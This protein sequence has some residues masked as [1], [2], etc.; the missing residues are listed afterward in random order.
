R[1]SDDQSRVVC[2]DRK[3]AGHYQLAGQVTCFL[4]HVVHSQP[5]NGEQEHISVFGRLGR[6]PRPRVG[7]SL[8]REPLQ[9][10]VA[11]RIAEHDFMSC[12]GKRWFQVFRPSVLNPESQFAYYNPVLF[13][14]SSGYRSPA[15]LIFSKAEL[16]P[17]PVCSE[18]E[19][20]VVQ[21][22]SIAF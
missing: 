10:I 16:S 5:M 22:V 8:S 13:S 3:R 18:A 21:P 19:E 20:I 15:T 2:I 11:S 4:Q 14:N 6:R 17:T 12:S 9:L 7:S 1:G